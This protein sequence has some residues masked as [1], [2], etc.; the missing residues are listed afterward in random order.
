MDLVERATI[1]EK[2]F[3][4]EDAMR[5][6]G[7]TTE[8]P[9]KHHFARGLY[10]RELF[11][12]KDTVLIGKIHKY[13]QLNVMAKG[14][15]SVLTEEGIKRVQAPFVIV[16]SPGTKRVAYAHEDTVWIT[17]HAT[18]ETDLEKIETRFI[19][20]NEQEYLDFCEQLKI[21]KAA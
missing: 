9:L 2:T 18:D 15:L 16:S 7:G 19:A 12:P 20:Q 1:R 10:A 13:E 14:D 17:I 11:I 3:V 5:A 4:L 6:L 21:E 8:L